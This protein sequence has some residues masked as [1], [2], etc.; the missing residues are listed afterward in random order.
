MVEGQDRRS[1]EDVIP[2]AGGFREVWSQAWPNV[3]TMS[4]FT[5]MQFVDALMVG[6]LGPLQLAAQGNGGVWSF[7]IIAF[8]FG[9]LTLV[10]TFT[11][12]N[13]GAGTPKLGP[14]YAW[15]G[16]WIAAGVW[17]VVLLP[18]AFLMPALFDAFGHSAELVEMEASYGGILLIGGIFIL[19]GKS[20]HHFFFGLHRPK[21]ITV[22]ALI[23]NVV[24]VCVTYFLVFGEDGL[25]WLGVPGIPGIPA[26]GIV[27]AA[28]GTVCG[29]FVELA[30][31]AAIFLGP[32]L[33][34]ELCT[35]AAWRP[36]WREIV[37]LFRVGWPASIQMGNEIICW[38]ALVTVLVGR[39]GEEH[40]SA[41]W[42]AIRYMHVSF[43]PAVGFSIATTA[44]VG[45]YVGAG[46][47]TTA[48]ARAR[49]SLWLAVGYMLACGVIFMV[50]RYPLI[51][52]FISDQGADVDPAQ[53]ERVVQIGAAVMIA[54]AVFQVFDAIGI[55]YNGALR[56][57]GD[58]IWPGVITV[59]FSWAFMVL[60]G[61]LMTVVFPD[62][63]S[64]GPW[65]AAGVYLGV[66]GITLAIRFERGRWRSISLL[67]KAEEGVRIPGVVGPGPPP[68]SAVGSIRDEL[69]GVRQPD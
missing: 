61:W 5:V 23:A 18:A 56:G 69:D 34:R 35:R 62:L 13:L 26:L 3:V 51:A 40:M 57:A 41:G 66:L 17:V 63:E 6:Q 33:N 50:F 7:T 10:N 21:V 65:I 29:G 20:L 28:I 48:V 60:G 8:V 27:G 68:L 32:K 49:L 19:S 39:F 37:D 45:R 16:C 42:A 31:P 2:R 12:Q 24:N 43:M 67:D 64:I 30:I 47:P 53:V 11:A 1:Q 14:R 38:A 22:T 46:D 9:L 52:L 59:V 4:S 36:R 58:T 54:A 15:A 55:I 25:S 44:L